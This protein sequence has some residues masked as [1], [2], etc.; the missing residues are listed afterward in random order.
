MFSKAALKKLFRGSSPDKNEEV[1]DT[2]LYFKHLDTT[3]FITGKKREI[4]EN[5]ATDIARRTK[6]FSDITGL[7]A[8][9]FTCFG[10][11]RTAIYTPQGADIDA[12]IDD[13]IDIRDK[14]GLGEP[15]TPHTQ[16]RKLDVY[17]RPLY[18]GNPALLTTR[19]GAKEMPED[20]IFGNF[21]VA[22]NDLTNE[23]L[24][25]LKK[26]S[27]IFHALVAKHTSAQNEQGVPEPN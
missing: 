20:E 9:S 10:P 25:K 11:T 18:P 27:K 3:C 8:K 16:M 5:E 2:D 1:I 24:D 4:P 19:E 14:T 7:K 15:R 12:F 23:N 21:Y 26:E 22:T 6:R 17:D 13:F